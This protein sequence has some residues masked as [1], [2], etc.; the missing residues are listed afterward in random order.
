ETV[1][2]AVAGEPLVSRFVME[3]YADV[4]TG[5]S[6]RVQYGVWASATYGSAG[7]VLPMDETACAPLPFELSRST[8]LPRLRR[9]SR[10]G[11][12]R[13]HRRSETMRVRVKEALE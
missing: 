8:H 9:A 12:V 6:D 2:I 13:R 4:T 3:R 1:D 10:V 7:A 5:E 11:R